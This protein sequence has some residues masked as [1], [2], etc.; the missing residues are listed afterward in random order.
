MLSPIYP[1]ACLASRMAAQKRA[2]FD[3]SEIEQV[4]AQTQTPHRYDIISEDE[5]LRELLALT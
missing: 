4:H 3:L 5:A 1:V 2:D